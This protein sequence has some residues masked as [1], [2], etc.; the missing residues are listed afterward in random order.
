MYWSSFHGLCYTVLLDTRVHH[1]D[2]SL[3]PYAEQ[4]LCICRT[5]VCLSVRMSLP[6][7]P[8]AGSK[9]DAVGLLLWAQPAGDI[10][11]LLHLCLLAF[12]CQL[13]FK[14]CVCQSIVGMYVNFLSMY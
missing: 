13:R 6:A 2:A 9:P 5:S 10:D 14:F 3:L 11:R 8:T 1:D 4:G 7:W 12:L